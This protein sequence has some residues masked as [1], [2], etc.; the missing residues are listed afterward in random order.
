M[1]YCCHYLPKFKEPGWWNC[2]NR[3]YCEGVSNPWQLPL[4]R[5]SAQISGEGKEVKFWPI[6]HHYSPTTYKKYMQS[7]G[8]AE[9]ERL[10]YG[11]WLNS[12]EVIDN[13]ISAGYAHAVALD[14]FRRLTWSGY[15][16][17]N[18]GVWWS[19]DRRTLR[20]VWNKYQL[21]NGQTVD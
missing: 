8:W 4:Q 15:K 14:Y 9:A 7:F 20:K 19:G 12:F 3:Y 13:K 16:K 6:P 17:D 11:R 18:N 21:R 5:L 10:P 1:G 2:P